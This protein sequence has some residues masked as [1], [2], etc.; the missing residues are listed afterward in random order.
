MHCVE[1]GAKN[2]RFPVEQIARGPQQYQPPFSCEIC[3]VAAN[4]I[5]AGEGEKHE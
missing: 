5:E 1:C 3:T 4:H 2:P